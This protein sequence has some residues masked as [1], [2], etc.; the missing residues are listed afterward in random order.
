MF[1]RNL[2]IA[3]LISFG[4]HIF[5]MLMVTIVSP[6]EHVRVQPYTRVDFLGPLLN[7][8]AFDIMLKNVNPLV[9]TM[10]QNIQMDNHYKQLKSEVFQKSFETHHLPAVQERVM[11]G[12]LS[13][14]LSGTKTA[15]DFLTEKQKD[16]SKGRKII[17]HPPVPTF[18]KELYGDKTI[19]KV[20]FRIYI[21]SDG[22]IEKA[23]PVTTTGYPQL[24]LMAAKF[25]R[26]W[27]F[28][29]K[30]TVSNY[31]EWHKV[32]VILEAGS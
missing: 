6:L 2:R 32:E 5:A 29:P 28:E 31:S 22:K 9:E 7:K 23:E 4:A 27:I 11:D 14:F 25:V 12:A 30:R 20:D 16:E 15:P 8:T 17:Y 21:N 13:D 18:I 19:C 10:Y 3:V 1:N 24:D 26:S